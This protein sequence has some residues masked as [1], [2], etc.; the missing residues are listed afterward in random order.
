MECGSVHRRNFGQLQDGFSNSM[1][2]SGTRASLNSGSIDIAV[3]S[4]AKDIALRKKVSRLSSALKFI[5]FSRQRRH[6][7]S[8]DVRRVAISSHFI[9]IVVSL[10]INF[11]C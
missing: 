4:S 11:V 5:H 9:L 7:I 1:D 6:K 8:A 2:N 10:K 3:M